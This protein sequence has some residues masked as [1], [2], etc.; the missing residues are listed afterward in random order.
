MNESGV[1]RLSSNHC[2]LITV[3]EFVHVELRTHKVCYEINYQ[4][5]E[6]NFNFLNF[7]TGQYIFVKCYYYANQVK[8]S[9]EINLKLD[10][11]I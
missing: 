1:I 9:F 3:C 10:N 8:E 4:C 5:N 6:K 2:L 7:Q 11:L